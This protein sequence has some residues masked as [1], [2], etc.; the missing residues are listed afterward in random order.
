MAEAISY[1]TLEMGWVGDWAGRRRCH[2]PDR[3]AVTDADTGRSWTYAALDDRASRVGRWLTRDLGLTRGDV[4]SFVARNRIEAIDLYLACGK[5]GIVLAPLSYRLAAPELTDLLARIRPRAVFVEDAFADLMADV[6]MPS[7]VAT[8]MAWR[9]S[10]GDYERTAL[11][12]E[13][14]DV[15]VPLAMAD[16]FLY[17]HTGGTTATPKVCIVPHRQMVWNSVELIVASPE[18]MAGRVELLLFPLFHIGGWNTFTPIFH[19]GGQIVL[20]REFDAGK[21]LRAIDELGVNHFG[22]VE[23]M[24]R[25]IA[26]HPDFADRGLASLR[27]ITTAGAACSAD[28]MKPF[29][30]RGIAVTQSY[31]QTEAGPSN[32][33]HGRLGGDM[34][35]MRA[36]HDSIGTSFFHCD[37]RIVDPESRVPV[38]RGQPG[39]LMM[40]SPHTFD[41]YLGQPERTAETV[42]ADGWVWSGD[43]A[44]EDEE[45]YVYLVGRA[46]NM[47]VSG[48]ENISP[49]EIERELGSHPDVSQVAV[50]GVPDEQWGQVPMAVIVAAGRTPEAQELREW[51]GGRVARFK[52][53]RRFAFAD[54]LPLTGAGKIDRNA[55]RRQ[56]AD[57]EHHDR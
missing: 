15:N 38:E 46:D 13:S 41:G 31:G 28:A 45:G 30:D 22:A 8:R 27:A 33:I 51:L 42:D 3:V 12:T 57:E 11:Q 18:A 9:D 17:I 4:I 5:T 6:T 26:R 49:E 55:A 52:I 53:P 44:R 48:G 2:S 20:L 21:V 1:D 43:L 35:E 14:D 25:F 37:Y 47:F 32:F 56:Y 50:F 34:D 19:A 54:E 36:R 10:D 23:A 24:L 39:V 40:R 16:T 29:W 7:S